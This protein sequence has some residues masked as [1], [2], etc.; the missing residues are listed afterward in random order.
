MATLESQIL[1][2]ITES[3][4][5]VTYTSLAR[6]FR[7]TRQAPALMVK[8]AVAALIASGELC[9]TS[10]Y[11]RSF[12]EPSFN[13]PSRVSEHIILAPPNRIVEAS[14]AERVIRLERGAS[15]GGGDH[16]TTRAAIALIDK[17]LH[18]RY[19]LEKKSR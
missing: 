7:R 13:R 19:W 15:F 14:M 18:A 5:K 9:Y 17:I 6:H 3:S 2:F 11:G 12:I 10:D 8:R 1:H 4:T 16:P